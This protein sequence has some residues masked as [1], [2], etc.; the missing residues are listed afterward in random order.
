MNQ[1]YFIVKLIDDVLVLCLN[2]IFDFL[3]FEGKFSLVYYQY[4]FSVY[5]LMDVILQKQVEIL[6]CFSIVF[7]CYFF[8]V[9]FGIEYDF[10][11]VL[12]G[13][14]EVLMQKVW[15][16]FLVIFLFSEQFIDWFDCFYGFYG[17]FICISVVVDSM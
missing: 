15:E 7:V 1:K 8:S 12:R 14:V 6:F 17:V 3:F 16:L 9:I 2:I 4:I 10:L 5:Y 11:L 13:Y